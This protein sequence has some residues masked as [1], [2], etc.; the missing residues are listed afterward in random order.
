MV[1]RRLY[2]QRDYENGEKVMSRLDRIYSNIAP[3]DALDCRITAAVVGA[4]NA[5][6]DHVSDHLPVQGRLTKPSHSTSANPIPL[7]ITKHACWEEKVRQRYEEWNS[8]G[9][10]EDPWA[11]VRGVKEVFRTAAMDVRKLSKE[12]GA[13]TSDE[14]LY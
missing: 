8:G 1:P 2:A 3:A 14:Q 4:T 12:R 11:Q 9:S 13:K 5:R 7:W 6:R 10:G